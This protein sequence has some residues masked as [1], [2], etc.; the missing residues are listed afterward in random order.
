MIQ[1]FCKKRSVL[2]VQASVL[3]EPAS[4][5]VT[6]KRGQLAIV[7]LFRGAGELVA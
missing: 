1:T 7:T 2:Y 6:D 3:G 5:P 4:W